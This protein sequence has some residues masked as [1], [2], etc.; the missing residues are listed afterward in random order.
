ME[1]TVRPLQRRAPRPLSA[2]KLA[3]VI[4]GDV[5]AFLRQEDTWGWSARGARWLATEMPLTEAI[6]RIAVGNHW[7]PRETLDAILKWKRERIAEEED[8][9]ASSQRRK[10][11]RRKP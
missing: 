6:E 8:D 9:A 2:R 11:A 1:E 3:S 5:D 4:P 10:S 7:S